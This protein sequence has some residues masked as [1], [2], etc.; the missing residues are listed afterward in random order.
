MIS[1]ALV[2]A[3]FACLA[4]LVVP[5]SGGFAPH[6]VGVVLAGCGGVVGAWALSANRPGNF[7][8]RPEPKAGGRL[9]TRGPY[10][11]VRHPMYVAVL[12][13]GAGAAA[14]YGEP[15]RWVV[16]VLLAL[17]LD[18]KAAREERALRGKFPAYADYAARTGR[19]LPRWR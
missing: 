9:V 11:H 14:A 2:F 12:L 19:F 17:V 16:L 13:F 1:A 8:I 5:P 18:R 3:Q 7:N 10:R 6:P 4:T 15:W